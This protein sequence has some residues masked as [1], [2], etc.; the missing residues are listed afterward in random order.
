[1]FKK[2]NE[3]IK[4]E[5]FGGVFLF[6]AAIL[7]LL[8]SNSSLSHYYDS[9]FE[10]IVSIT[11][12]EIGIK[13][14]LIL[15]IN[16]GL[17]AVFFCLV[18]LE[19]KQEFKFGE[20]SNTSQIM[21][22][23]TAALGGML[24]PA[25]IYY[26]IVKDTMP[27]AING[28]AI[29]TATDIA[30][31]LGVLSLFSKSIPYQLKVLL[32]AI[33]I[34]DDLASILIIAI[35]YTANLSWS[36][37]LIS[38]VFC[39]FLF[40]LNKKNINSLGLYVFVG[41]L[42]WVCV[43]NSGVHATLAGVVVALAMPFEK[44]NSLGSHLIKKIHPWV[45]YVVIPT[46]A[47]ANAGI[48]L[49]SVDLSFLLNKISLG[50]FFGLVVGKPLGIVGFSWLGECLQLFKRPTGLSWYYILAVSFLC[51]IGFTMSLFLG[52]LA[53][54]SSHLHVFVKLGVFLGSI[55]AGIIGS[56]LLKC[57]KV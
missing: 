7:A 43:L 45:I 8:I 38:L 18:V 24:V 14:P 50:I 2:F 44:Q 40:L 49:T 10:S 6:F 47:F 52:T 41:F 25:F 48:N 21:F 36:M 13:K 56:I 55:I 23:A 32:T 37:I 15:W 30:F 17:M 11:F 3:F 34:F 29:P 33:A 28:W 27:I 9:F 42:L 20:L 4:L 46:F 16:E 51:G 39:F 12:N 19:L 1:M 54:D 31:S 53:F 22:P 57:A 35:Y 5:S 26:F